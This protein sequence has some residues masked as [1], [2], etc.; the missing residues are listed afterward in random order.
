MRLIFVIVI[1]LTF[2]RNSVSELVFNSN[3]LL[4]QFYSKKLSK[5][6]KELYYY[7]KERN[8]LEK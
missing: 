2:S 3:T 6:Q 8:S 7:H 4:M 1:F 5:I